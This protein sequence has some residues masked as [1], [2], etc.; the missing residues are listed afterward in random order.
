M[1]KISTLTLLWFLL[2]LSAMVFGDSVTVKTEFVPK[3]I[4]TLERIRIANT[5][6]LIQKYYFKVLVYTCTI[7]IVLV[8]G[9]II[10]WVYRTSLGKN[11]VEYQLKNT[12]LRLKELSL[13][14]R[15]WTYLYRSFQASVTARL[16]FT[17]SSIT[18][19]HYEF[20]SV[21]DKVKQQLNIIN[22]SATKTLNHIRS[23]TNDETI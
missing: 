16:V 1:G 8:F 18:N 7:M 21:D 23:M 19:V 9:Y 14:H 12:H 5:E 4:S 17:I 10:L 13:Q 6:T 22:K 11:D 3:A 15:N 20:D 2:L